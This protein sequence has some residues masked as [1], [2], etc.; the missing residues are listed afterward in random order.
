MRTTFVFLL[1]I[2]CST[3]ALSQDLCENV[4][5]TKSFPNF[6]YQFDSAGSVNFQWQNDIGS[7]KRVGTYRL[8]QDTIEITYKPVYSLE[9]LD[10]ALNNT[11][12][13]KDSIKS[14]FRSLNYKVF[15]GE[16]FEYYSPDS[17][18][19]IIIEN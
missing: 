4:W 3:S 12:T 11:L 7:Y 15:L 1:V 16:E 17:N 8:I 2:F 13:L 10:T 18:G 6:L 5:S 14:G 9:H 19:I